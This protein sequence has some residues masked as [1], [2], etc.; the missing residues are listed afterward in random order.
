MATWLI[1]IGAFSLCNLYSMCSRISKWDYFF[2]LDGRY[3]SF[4]DQENTFTD[5]LKNKEKLWIIRETVCTEL[6]EVLILCRNE[7]FLW[8]ELNMREKY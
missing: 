2:E 8:G 3:T 7:V 5:E 4:T 6:M 1:T